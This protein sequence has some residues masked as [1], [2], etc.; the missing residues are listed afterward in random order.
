MTRNRIPL[1]C[2]KVTMSKHTVA[3]RWFVPARTATVPGPTHDFACE[4]VIRWALSDVGA[5]PM[6]QCVRESLIYTTAIRVGEA[7]VSTIATRP[8]NTQLVLFD[9]IAA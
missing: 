8:A 1:T 2:W 7:S 4:Q 5:P 9:R 6:R 3:P